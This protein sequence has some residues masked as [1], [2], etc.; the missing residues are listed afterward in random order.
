[1]PYHIKRS[2]RLAS[3]ITVYYKGSGGWTDNYSERIVYDS[4]PTPMTDNP[5]G[6]NGGWSDCVIVSE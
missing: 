5:N 1:M 4:D 2:S 3:G 6:K